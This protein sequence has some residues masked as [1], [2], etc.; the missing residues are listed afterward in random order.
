MW[1][2]AVLQAE[3][4]RGIASALLQENLNKMRYKGIKRMEF[5]VES[6]N[7]AALKMFKQF[8]DSHSLDMLELETYNTEHPETGGQ[9]RVSMYEMSGIR[10]A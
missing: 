5:A 3:Q 7:K 2:L 6:E 10:L 9:V 1:Q 4:R 8:S